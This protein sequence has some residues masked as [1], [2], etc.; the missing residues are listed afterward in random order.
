M[1]A[2][3]VVFCPCAIPATRSP[4][5]ARQMTTERSL[6]GNRTNG[7]AL[8]PY[9]VHIRRPRGGASQAAASASALGSAAPSPAGAKRRR[10]AAAEAGDDDDDE[11]AA[12]APAAS[13]AAPAR[14][15]SARG[16]RGASSG[17]SPAGGPL[18]ALMSPSGGG[19]RASGGAS[20]G[21]A[22]VAATA[23]PSAADYVARACYCFG[24]STI[25]VVAEGDTDAAPPPGASASDDPSAPSARWPWAAPAERV[26]ACGLN[27]YGQAST[28]RGAE[29]SRR[30]GTH[31]APPFPPF[32]LPPCQL[33]TGDTED[34]PAP[35]LV[36]GLCG[37]GVAAV[38]G[39][40]AH[41]LVLLRAGAVLALGR[42]DSGQLGLSEARKAPV[43]V[44][45]CALQPTMLPPGA[46]GGEAVV[47]VAASACR[48]GASP[49]LP[50]PSCL[51]PACSLSACSLLQLCG[52]GGL[53]S[54]LHVGLWGVGA[55]RKRR[56]RFAGRKRAV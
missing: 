31:A 18:K 43:P 22:S 49:L 8:T 4:S 9:P 42:G 21:G 55:A 27:N 45:A 56:R 17:R 39:G 24:Y 1:L 33:G 16:G 14:K 25:I 34:R 6:R 23:V 53:R 44:A 46:F 28:G 54:P 3:P 50:C 19:R 40:S 29:W 26:Y 13:A 5:T 20:S 36:P 7:I 41:A 51:L 37:L 48:C 15:G 12:E 47:E 38:A 10:G 11:P 30:S 52:C 35:T 32:I 2:C